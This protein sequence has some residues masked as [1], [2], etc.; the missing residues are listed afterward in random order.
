MIRRLLFIVLILVWLSAVAT[1]IAFLWSYN[2]EPG[3]AAAAPEHL[4]NTSFIVR[5]PGEFTLVMTVHPKCPCTRASI[6]ELAKLMTNCQGRLRASVLLL[7]PGGAPE[8]W[9]RTDLWKSAAAIP[10]VNVLIDE[11]GIEASRFGAVT[12]GQVLLYAS[13]GS[14]LFRGGITQSRG[15]IGDNAGRS[16]IESLVDKGSA[17]RESTS[18]F[19]CPLFD[20]NSECREPNHGKASN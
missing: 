3:V 19:G 5:E 14:L 16:A 13:S 20:Q 17:D 4:P 1:G 9:Y 12:S 11:D 6:E 15:H 18:V 8:E 2:H 10:G 7:K